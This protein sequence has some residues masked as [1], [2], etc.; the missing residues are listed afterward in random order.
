MTVPEPHRHRRVSSMTVSISTCHRYS[1][2]MTGATHTVIDVFVDD[3]LSQRPSSRKFVD[4]GVV[5]QPKVFPFSF[6]PARND[7]VYPQS[8]F[9]TWYVQNE[10]VLDACGG[11]A[12]AAGRVVTRAGG[13]AGRACGRVPRMPHAPPQVHSRSEVDSLCTRGQG[14]LLRS[15]VGPL[16]WF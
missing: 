8:R 1:L 12:G 10:M 15:G 11:A 9:T 3:G 13:R 14:H 6:F 7:L 5:L 2:S 4:D 16:F